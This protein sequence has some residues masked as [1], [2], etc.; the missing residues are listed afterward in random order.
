MEQE[1]KSIEQ[2]FK[3][4]SIET[5]YDIKLLVARGAYKTGK[6]FNSLKLKVINNK[7]KG[8]SATLEMVYYGKYVD[9][10]HK[11]RNGKKLKGVHFTKPMTELRKMMPKL[12]KAYAEYI[13]KSLIKEIKN[14]Q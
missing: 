4:W 6:L 10:G 7:E 9:Q 2:F 13:E 12:E 8:Y 5:F 14:K 3:E 1:I 11:L